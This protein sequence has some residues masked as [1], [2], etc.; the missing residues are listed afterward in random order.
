MSIWLKLIIPLFKH[1]CDERGMKDS[2]DISYAGNKLLQQYK[3]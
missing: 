3:N 1:A 2:S